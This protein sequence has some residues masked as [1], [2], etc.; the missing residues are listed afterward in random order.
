MFDKHLL[1]DE[2]I[3]SVMTPLNQTENF[4]HHEIDSDQ[5]IIILN[6][7]DFIQ[8]TFNLINSS[9]NNSSQLY[10]TYENGSDKEAEQNNKTE[11]NEF[12]PTF[13]TEPVSNDSDFRLIDL[14]DLTACDDF[15]L[16]DLF[17]I[18]DAS[19]QA[20]NSNQT[21]ICSAS[22]SE[23]LKI[24]K[25]E[26]DFKMLNTACFQQEIE[27]IVINDDDLE[28]NYEDKDYQLSI[29]LPSFSSEN[30]HS[31]KSSKSLQ[32]TFCSKTFNKIY[33]FKRHLLQHES[34]NNLNECPNCTRKI[35]DK[36]NFSKH[37]KICC[38]SEI[39]NKLSVSFKTVQKRNR[40]S[41]KKLNEFDCNICGKEFKKKFNFIRHLKV[42]S[43]NSQMNDNLLQP[44]VPNVSSKYF[45][46]EKCKRCFVEQKQLQSHMK[47]WHLADITC[48]YCSSDNSPVKFNEKFDYIKHLNT[49]HSF[50]FGFECKHCSKNFRFFSHYQEHR[51]LHEEVCTSNLSFQ[52][53]FSNNLK[54][55][56]S[57]L[58]VHN[59]SSNKIS[60]CE[61]CG[62]KFAK[63]HNFKRHIEIHYSKRN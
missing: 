15:D 51:K 17:L 43:L 11:K 45:Q 39:Q 9:T 12:K 42:H 34:Q 8:A 18:H 44:Y 30:D 52:N 50:N 19:N 24:V 56:N 25:N 29:S 36:S 61:I 7:D 57:E 63:L 40:T 46:C 58:L 48:K 6:D 55:V 20:V 1:D 32:C 3:E 16:N 28:E 31:F 5:D 2:I 37:L 47:T 62:K 53:D 23:D 41:L 10:N 60:K 22:Q 54:P 35:L 21:E 27:E 14:I 38:K 4:V 33:N 13:Y 26:F 49:F 59:L